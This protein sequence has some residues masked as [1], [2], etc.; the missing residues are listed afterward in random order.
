MVNRAAKIRTCFERK[1]EGRAGLSLYFLLK[2]Y[3]VNFREFSFDLWYNR[4]S[5][6]GRLLSLFTGDKERIRDVKPSKIITFYGIYTS[7]S[8]LDILINK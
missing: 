6:M 2:I 3:E 1:K 8:C 4:N 5:I 7:K